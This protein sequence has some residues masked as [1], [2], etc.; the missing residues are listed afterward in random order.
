M[1]KRFFFAV[2]P[3]VLLAGSVVADDSLLSSIAKMDLSGSAGNPTASDDADELGQADVDALLGDDEGQSTEEAVAA[4]FRRIGYGYGYRSYGYRSY[5][6]YRSWCS[7]VYRTYYSYPSLH[8]YR[9]VTYSY[10]TP[11]YTHYWG[12][13]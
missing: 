10:Y 7:P 3:M 11:V 6:G 12:C 13:W 2:A 8:C 9:P 1:L 5:R 4:C